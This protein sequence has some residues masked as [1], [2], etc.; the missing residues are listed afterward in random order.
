[1]PKQSKPHAQT[2]RS[3]FL[4]KLS[5]FAAGGGSASVVAPA[6]AVVVAP[7]FAVGV[8]PG[9]GPGFSL[10]IQAPTKK[11]FHSAEGRSEGEAET[12][13]ISPLPLP[14]LPGSG[15]FFVEGNTFAERA[16][17]VR[18]AHFMDMWH[19]QVSTSR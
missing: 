3:S 10:D 14:V 5:S 17:S 6:F 12:T 19:I 16:P 9:V 11:P 8:A 4:K 15:L 1:M 2:M 7:A 13:E 18:D